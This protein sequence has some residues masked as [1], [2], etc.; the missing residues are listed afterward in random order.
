MRSRFLVRCTGG[1]AKLPKN[2][3][4]T[5]GILLGALLGKPGGLC[6]GKGAGL[7]RVGWGVTG[8]RFF[9]QGCPPFI[10]SAGYLPVGRLLGTNEGCADGRFDGLPAGVC[11]LG[12]RKGWWWP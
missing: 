1:W 3:I 6:K 9:F 4:R 10:H 2:R 5:V 8:G 11:M 12:R 7:V